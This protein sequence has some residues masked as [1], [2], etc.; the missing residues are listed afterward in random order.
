MEKKLSSPGRTRTYDP[1]VNS[2]LL[3]QLSYRGMDRSAVNESRSADALYRA[4]QSSKPNGGKLLANLLF[5]PGIVRPARPNGRQ[6]PGLV[7]RNF[8]IVTQLPLSLY[9]TL[10]M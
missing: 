6:P 4:R 9:S 1:A 2:R 5:L 8:S 7:V 10:V 3:Y